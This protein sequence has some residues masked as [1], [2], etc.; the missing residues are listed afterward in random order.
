MLI[1]CESK[2]LRWDRAFTRYAAFYGKVAELRWFVSKN[3]PFD[4]TELAV[5]AVSGQRKG[6]L[7]ILKWLHTECVKHTSGALA[8]ALDCAGFMGDRASVMWLRQRE[9]P[10][11]SSFTFTPLGVK[12]PNLAKLPVR[13]ALRYWRA[14]EMQYALANGANWGCWRCQHLCSGWYEKSLVER[15]RELFEWAHKQPGCPCTCSRKAKS[16][17]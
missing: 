11:P 12:E 17:K 5:N 6:K 2:G 15:T 1:L 3:C 10:W 7:Q 13:G 8:A 14:S 16:G 4:V 9:V